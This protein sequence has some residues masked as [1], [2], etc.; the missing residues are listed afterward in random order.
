MEEF[1][2][3]KDDLTKFSSSAFGGILGT[4][5]I[6]ALGWMVD[7]TS[8]GASGSGIGNTTADSQEDPELTQALSL[9][10]GIGSSSY[11]P[12]PQVIIT[13]ANNKPQTKVE[14]NAKKVYDKYDGKHVKAKDEGASMVIVDAEAGAL[15]DSIIGQSNTKFELIRNLTALEQALVA[16]KE[17]SA[18]KQEVKVK[19]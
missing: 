16:A 13:L 4:L 15:F 7:Q 14:E 12:N 19:K 17:A 1:N 2:V 5:S 8:L 10:F 18:D 9:G 11:T 3:A 6:G